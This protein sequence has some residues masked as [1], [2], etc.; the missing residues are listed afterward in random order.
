MIKQDILENQAKTVFLAIGSNLGDKKLNI[1][2]AKIK[3]LDYRIKILKSSNFYKSNSWPDKKN[4]KF[5][6]I[7]IKVK[8]N[9][10]PLDL[11]NI[12]KLIEKSLGRKKAYKNAPRICDIDIV[13]YNK[14]IINLV[15]K[16]LIL[17]HPSLHKRNF[18]LLPLY[19]INRSWKHPKYKTNIVKLINSLTIYDLRSIKRI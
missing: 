19:E 15:D 4:P 13:D 7:V 1:E 6:N 14:K 3:L 12:C 17:P 10:S 2:R 5:L 18:V 11:L 9:K 16:K 8:T